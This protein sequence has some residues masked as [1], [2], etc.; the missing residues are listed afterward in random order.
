MAIKLITFDFY[1]TL[2]KF[3]PP[4]EEIQIEACRPFRLDV[5]PAGIALGYRAADAF[6][7]MEVARQPLRKRSRDELRMFFAEYESLVLQGDGIQVSYEVARQ[8]VKSVRSMSHG[9]ELYEDVLG[10]LEILKRKG[11]TLGLISN[12][13]QTS[14]NLMTEVG[15]KG[16]LH[17]AVTSSE[18]S[19]GKPHPPIFTKALNKANVKASE[20]IHVGDQYETDVKGALNIG[21]K[22]ILI[23]RD[24]HADTS[25]EYPII[26]GLNEIYEAIDTISEF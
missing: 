4:R 14:E 17:F 21:K 23:E 11:F 3:K 13:E 19:M 7:A 24:G 1:N 8:I 16:Y 22:A 18:V 20:G 6:M 5:T 26:S 15:L 10:S 9:F 12:N 2:G 25:K